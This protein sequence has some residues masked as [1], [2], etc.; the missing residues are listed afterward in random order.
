MLL[1]FASLLVPLDKYTSGP[2]AARVHVLTAP[3]E[4]LTNADNYVAYVLGV[5]DPIH[6]DEY[7]PP[8]YD[9]PPYNGRRD[10]EVSNFS[11]LPM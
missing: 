2:V 8:S 10:Y 3:T 1:N 6:P 5:S 11:S 9:P 4:V 7:A